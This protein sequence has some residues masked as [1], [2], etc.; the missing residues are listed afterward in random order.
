LRPDSFSKTR[1]GFIAPLTVNFD[2]FW[3]VVSHCWTRKIVKWYGTL[4]D[5]ED[6]KRHHSHEIKR[7]MTAAITSANSCMEWLT[8]EP[9]NLDRARAEVSKIDKYGN[10]ATE[11]IRSDTF[12]LQELPSAS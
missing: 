5:I 7:P 10:R 3:C 12:V 4:T 1:R 2:G 9:P 8:H 6:R 11:I